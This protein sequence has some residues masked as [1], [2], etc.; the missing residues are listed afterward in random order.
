MC[1]DAVV[2]SRMPLYVARRTSDDGVTSAPRWLAM[3]GRSCAH[4]AKAVDGAGAIDSCACAT[5]PLGSG[6]HRL[7][8]L[9]GLHALHHVG[10]SARTIADALLPFGEE[11]NVG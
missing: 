8:L 10:H 6:A 7:A 9:E 2:R 11:G 1:Q 4:E 3:A 5:G